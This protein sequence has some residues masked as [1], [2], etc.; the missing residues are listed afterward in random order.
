MDEEALEYRIQLAHDEMVNDA[1]SEFSG[2]NLAFDGAIDDESDA[3]ADGICPIHNLLVEANEI[4]LV[5]ELEFDGT[6]G[7]SLVF[8]A[9]V[10]GGEEFGE[11]H[12]LGW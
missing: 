8:S 5:V 11:V 2:E 1:V 3:L 7:I 10:V 6:G 4:R 9:I 12:Y